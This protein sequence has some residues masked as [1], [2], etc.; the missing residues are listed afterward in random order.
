MSDKQP[1][2]LRLADSLERMSLS[3]KWDKQ[4]AAELRRLHEVNQELLEAL[5]A[6]EMRM[7]CMDK[8]IEWEFGD[9]RA[10]DEMEADKAWSEE[11]YKA[12]AAI[13][14]ATGEEV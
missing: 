8:T 10:E 2:A 1:E 4:A 3:T 13:S 11:V 5:K 14:K 7:R 12:R 6:A 9:C